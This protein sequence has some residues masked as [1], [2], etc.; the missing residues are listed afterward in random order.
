MQRVTAA[1][2]LIALAV[3]RRFGSG[4]RRAAVPSDRQFDCC[5]CG[6]SDV[7]LLRLWPTDLVALRVR[8]RLGGDGRSS[9]PVGAVIIE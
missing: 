2:A 7:T 8:R 6:V 1:A 3:L 5:V 4:R 9:P